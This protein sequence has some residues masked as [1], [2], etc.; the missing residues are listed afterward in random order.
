[1]QLLIIGLVILMATTVTIM[2]FTQPKIKKNVKTQNQ[3][4]PKLLR[5]QRG[6]K[7]LNPQQQ[8]QLDKLNHHNLSILKQMWKDEHL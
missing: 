7:T 3:K 2:Y 5:F 1:M 6:N 8:E 4:K